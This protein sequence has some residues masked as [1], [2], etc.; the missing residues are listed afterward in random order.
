MEF[1][2]SLDF[3]RVTQYEPLPHLAVRAKVRCEFERPI[4]ELSHGKLGQLADVRTI[5]EALEAEMLSEKVTRWPT[6]N[7]F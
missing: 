7:C 1:T 5:E 4:R 3:L 6:S 2:S